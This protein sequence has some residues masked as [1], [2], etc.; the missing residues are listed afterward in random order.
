MSGL[1]LPASARTVSVMKKLPFTVRSR[2]VLAACA[3]MLGLAFVAFTGAAL[4]GSTALPASATEPAAQPP[5]ISPGTTGRALAEPLPPPRRLRLAILPDRTTGRDWGLKYLDLAVDDLNRM[6]PDAVL[7]VGDMIQGYTRSVDQWLAERD[8]FHR[9]VDRLSMPFYPLPGN[10]EVVSGSRR[11]DDTTFENLYKD[12]FGPLYYAANFDLATVIMLY[13]DDAR[14]QGGGEGIGDEQRA[15]LERELLLAKERGKP[16]FVLLHRPLWRSR[17]SG[18]NETIHPLLAD[19][20]VRAVIAGH[21]HSM[22]RDPDRDGVEHHILAVCGGMI[23]Q[24]PLTGQFQHLTFLT[25]DEDGAFAI[26]HQP[27]GMTIPDDFILTVDQDRSFRLK[28]MTRDL[29]VRGALRDPVRGAVDQTL[30]VEIVN[31]VDVPVRVS[32]VM[33]EQP[34]GPVIPEGALWLSRTEQ[35]IFNHHVTETDS[36]LSLDESPGLVQL[37]PGERTTFD[38]RFTCPPQ[39]AP[40]APAELIFRIVFTDSRGRE[41][42]IF[43]RRRVPIELDVPRLAESPQRRPICAWFPSVYDTLEPNPTV[44][45]TFPERGRMMIDLHVQ[46][47]IRSAYADESRSVVERFNDPMSDAVLI[48][49]TTEAGVVGFYIEPFGS[50][51]VWRIEGRTARVETEAEAILIEP[52]PGTEAGWRLRVIVPVPMEGFGLNI[53]VADND[54][55]YH[56]QWRYLAPRDVPARVPAHTPVPTIPP[57][58]LVPPVPAEH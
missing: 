6:Q 40:I 19:A 18:W 2:F 41:V 8:E 50:E 16:I 53:G 10:H 52:E 47:A 38:L 24:H 43:V 55:T 39:T 25:I 35:D 32:V 9:A 49:T 42:P 17:R 33:V 12:H 3:L 5:G 20:G 36:P 26:H 31:P 34:P 48:Q 51:R 22:Q 1:T 27:V 56:T 29:Q 21:F 11:N 14:L 13:S 44:G 57:I 15:W 28:S 23:D 4:P 37:A 58:P 45:I 46:D 54:E 30:Q 7:S